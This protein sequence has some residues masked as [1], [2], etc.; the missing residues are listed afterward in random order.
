[1]SSVKLVRRRTAIEWLMEPWLSGAGAAARAGRVC[2]VAL[3]LTLVILPG[4]IAYFG[5]DDWWWDSTIAICVLTPVGIILFDNVA[6]LFGLRGLWRVGALSG[7]FLV[8]NIAGY[9]AIYVFRPLP[10]RTADLLMADFQRNITI[11]GPIL[12]LVVVVGASLWYRAEAYRLESV[13]TAA[14]FNVLKGQMQP[15][16][17]FNALNALKELI[18]DDPATARVVTQR[19]A[20]LYRMILKVST[21]ATTPLADELSIVEH[22]LEIERVRYGERLS[23]SIEAPDDLKADHVPSLVLQTLVENAIKHGIS[24]ARAGGKVWV[25]ASRSGGGLELEVSNTGAPFEP[26]GAGGTG[27]ANTRARLELM[28]GAASELTISADATLGTRVRLV[29]SGSRVGA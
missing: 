19:L 8:G 6:E 9:F 27:L 16:F 2:A 15:H 26:N 3:V 10:G 24:K 7:G 13:A 21:E 11:L 1:V 29:V 5:A 12:A 25:R 18:A 28:Y 23:Y 14:S 4:M 22:Y 17:L 20:D